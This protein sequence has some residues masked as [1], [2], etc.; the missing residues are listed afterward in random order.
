MGGFMNDNK[1]FKVGQ[2][3]KDKE[4]HGWLILMIDDDFM[5]CFCGS[6]ANHVTYLNLDGTHRTNDGCNLIEFVGEFK[7]E[8]NESI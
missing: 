8:P 4:G 5:C 1:Q 3:W 7:G 6:R 2:I